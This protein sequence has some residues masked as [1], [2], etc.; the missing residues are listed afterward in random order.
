MIDYFCL[1]TERNGADVT[2]G[3]VAASLFQ[4]YYPAS[5]RTF[6]QLRDEGFCGTNLFAFRGP[7]AAAAA[8]FWV[9]A[10]QFRKR[11]W[12]LVSTFGV[13]ALVLFALR[14]L[15]LQAAIRRA[16]DRLGVC[17][18]VVP[19]PFAE[20]AIDVDNLDDLTLASRILDEREKG[21]VSQ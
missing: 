7:Q 18:R 9:H 20:C 12:R 1:A 14:R 6:I 2:V 10:G 4:A 3:V 8:K 15:D 19:M 11:P 17:I 13:T 5:K 21:I 16:S